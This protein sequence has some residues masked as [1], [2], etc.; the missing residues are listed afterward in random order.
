MLRIDRPKLTDCILNVSL[1][2]FISIHKKESAYK[3]T[4]QTDCI[5]QGKHFST[6]IY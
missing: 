5:S 3:F 2:H 6:H 1:I 4:H